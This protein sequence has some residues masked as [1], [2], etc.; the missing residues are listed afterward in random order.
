MKGAA[1]N[2]RQSTRQLQRIVLYAEP[3]IKF[4]FGVLMYY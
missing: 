1:S 2:L 3:N 4:S